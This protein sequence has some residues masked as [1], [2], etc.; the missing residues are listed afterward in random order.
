[1]H[2]QVDSLASGVPAQGDL[3]RTI[4]RVAHE[5]RTPVTVIAGSLENLQE[6][7]DSLVRYVAAMERYLGEHDEASRLRR[8]LRLDYRIEN[9]PGLLRICSEGAERLRHVVDQLRVHADPAQAYAAGKADLADVLRASVALARVERPTAPEID[10]QLPPSLGYVRGGQQFLGQVFL[11]LVRNALDAV[12][13]VPEPHV[14]V[15]VAPLDDRPDEAL[16]VTVRDN[17]PG[18]P[19][20]LR[21]RVFD[22]FFTTKRASQGVGL[23]LAIS[24][25][26]VVALGGSIEIASGPSGGAEVQ[27]VLPRVPAA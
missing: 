1:M 15:A 25:D 10:W 6:S 9:T 8:D 22:E 17:G 14:E 23:G 24:R 18:I 27:V 12:A 5:L 16:V 21:E 4:A 26:I 7:M 13:D 20:P 19:L 2:H 11:N 3:G